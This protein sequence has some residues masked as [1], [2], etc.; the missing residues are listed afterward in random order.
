MTEPP[1]G[2][3]L[4][5]IFA[6][7]SFKGSVTSVDV[8]RA[9]AAGWARG[10]PADWLLLA[11]LADGG[12][13]TLVAIEAAGGWEWREARVQDPLGRPTTARWLA[14]TAGDR[15]VVEMAQSSGLSLV[16]PG[17]RDPV[18]AHTYGTGEVLAAVLD[19]GIRRIT[20]GIGGSATS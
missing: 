20:L 10:R 15:A 17:E 8:A 9:L 12:E 3:R 11:P 5:V 7:D 14:S 16:D 1:G 18:G 19:A 6:P 4:T 2:R 13:G